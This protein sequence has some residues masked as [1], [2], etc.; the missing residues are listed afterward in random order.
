LQSD[1]DCFLTPRGLTIPDKDGNQEF[2]F[3]Q[4]KPFAKKRYRYL[5]R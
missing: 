2:D 3:R 1:P 4:L 5:F